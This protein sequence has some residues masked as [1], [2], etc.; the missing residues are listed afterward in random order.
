MLIAIVIVEKDLAYDSTL[1]LE[2]VILSYKSSLGRDLFLPQQAHQQ[3]FDV[4]GAVD[5]QTLQLGL[6]RA[7]CHT[8]I[9]A[10][11]CH[12]VEDK[13]LLR[14]SLFGLQLIAQQ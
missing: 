3:F 14:E 9:L 6:F 11:Y 13:D 7:L 10:L 5:H 4:Y 12:D 1:L 2:Y 8:A